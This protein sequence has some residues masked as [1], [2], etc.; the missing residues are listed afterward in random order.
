MELLF[1]CEKQLKI[2]FKKKKQMVTEDG[3]FVD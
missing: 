1:T 2:K 3:K